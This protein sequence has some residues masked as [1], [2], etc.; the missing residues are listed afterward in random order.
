M[1]LDTT[2]YANG[3]AGPSGALAPTDGRQAAAGT[4][5]AKL[6]QQCCGFESVFLNE[7]MKSMR[8]TVPDSKGIMAQSNEQKQIQTMYDEKLSETMAKRGTAG[9]ATR[10][11]D[12]F[13]RHDLLH[14]AQQAGAT[15]E[16]A[17]HRGKASS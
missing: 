10:L 12:D 8:K 14:Q 5:A 9:L 6:W 3:K 1:Q 15:D 11:Y 7:M 16:S 2:S 4:R 13:R 17:K